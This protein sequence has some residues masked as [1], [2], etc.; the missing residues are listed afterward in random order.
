MNGKVFDN[1]GGSDRDRRRALGKPQVTQKSCKCV[2]GGT[3]AVLAH[4]GFRASCVSSECSGL[5]EMVKN[6][7]AGH[8]WNNHTTVFKPPL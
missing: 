6:E 3:S 5:V 2:W 1:R 4:A 8:T 7:E